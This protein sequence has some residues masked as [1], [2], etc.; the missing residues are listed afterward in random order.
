MKRTCAGPPTRNQV[1]PASDWFAMR[2]PRSSGIALRRS[3]TMSGKVIMRLPGNHGRCVWSQRRFG[4]G[5]TTKAR[6]NSCRLAQA[7]EFIGERAGP[8][9]D[10]A[11]AEADHVVA[12]R[13]QAFDD[14][15]E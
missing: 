9:G 13:G 4:P 7:G 12:A 3:G 5:Y 10:V 6:W 2:R 14:R 8:L 1:R 11:G 15:R